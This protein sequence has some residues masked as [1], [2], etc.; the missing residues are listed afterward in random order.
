MQLR[1]YHAMYSYIM[2]DYQL[3]LNSIV[4]CSAQSRPGVS[5]QESKSVLI[6]A[7]L[8]MVYLL[9]NPY[10]HHLTQSY[11]FPNL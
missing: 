7:W 6:H 2:H 1:G 9:T 5:F 10:M 11:G 3:Y 8:V 4:I